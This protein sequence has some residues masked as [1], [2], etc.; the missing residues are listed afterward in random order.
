MATAGEGVARGLPRAARLGA[1]LFCALVLA[2]PRAATVGAESALDLWWTRLV[3]ALLPFLL[4]AEAYLWGS[5]R[6]PTRSRLWRRAP[7]LAGLPEAAGAPLLASLL[8]GY[9][10]AGAL[11]DRFV[12]AGRLSPA[13]GARL[14][15]LA[16]VPDPLFVAALWAPALGPAHAIAPILLAVQYAALIPVVLYLR[17][18]STASDHPTLDRPVPVTAAG[19]PLLDAAVGAARTLL[20]V[21]V[22]MAALGALAAATRALLHTWTAWVLP[23]AWREVGAGALDA[24]ILAEPGVPL[25]L[26]AALALTSALAALGGAVLWLET[27]AVTRPSGLDLRPFVTARLLQAATAAILAAAVGWLLGPQLGAPVLGALATGPLLAPWRIALTLAGGVFGG[28]LAA[29]GGR[30]SRPS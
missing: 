27:W 13:D 26:P 14:V 25:A 24:L 28:A 29:A 7:R 10:T 21:A 5:A 22:S 12:R 17:R 20:L 30:P 4:A 15:A 1:L 8:G 11:A 3:P 6:G 23:P 9:P 2:A 16:S 18:P 19:D